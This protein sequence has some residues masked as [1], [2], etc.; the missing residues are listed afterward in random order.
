MAKNQV[1]GILVTPHAISYTTLEQ[2]QDRWSVVETRSVPLRDAEPTLLLEQEPF[3]E[4][5]RPHTTAWSG[6]CTLVVPASFGMLRIV[7]LPSVDE[8][9]IES[10]VE[11]QVD[12][13]SPFP[14]EQLQ[15]SYE[16]I[17]QTDRTT[18]VIVVAVLLDRIQSLG[19]ACLGLGLRVDRIDVDILGWWKSIREAG[20]VAKNGRGISILCETDDTILLVTENGSPVMVRSLG[21]QEEASRDEYCSMIAEETE[22]ALTSVEAEWGSTA[23][24]GCRLWHRGDEQ[25][26]LAD[27]LE[28]TCGFSV[29]SHALDSLKPLSESIALRTTEGAD[30]FVNLA[31]GEWEIAYRSKVTQR[32]FLVATGSMLIVWLLIVSGFLI[33]LGIQR[34][35]LKKVQMHLE[36]LKGPAEEVRIIKAN[37]L[38]LEEY[39]NRSN[40]ALETLR[41]IAMAMPDGVELNQ[42]K[43]AAAGKVA[44]QGVSTS[45]QIVLTFQE[46]LQLV[47]TLEEVELE[48]MGAGGRNRTQI[49]FRFT[50]TSPEASL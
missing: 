23:T 20:E 11:L 13:Y 8:E 31:P 48:S 9:E 39:T 33:A 43:F 40:S 17:D 44:F 16:S 37:A 41:S 2:K 4:A 18:R 29:T 42:F 3:S 6:R 28:Q 26:D 45:Q 50:A 12:K 27:V 5:L 10:M 35:G 46:N 36:G 7:D 22:Y 32:N 25:P 15:I 24:L 49:T 14:V 19:E 47:E 21:P 30:E 1:H 34:S 38:F